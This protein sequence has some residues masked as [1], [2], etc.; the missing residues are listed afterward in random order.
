MHKYFKNQNFAFPDEQQ[1]KVADIDS[2]VF[3]F[4]FVRNPWDRLL[5][6]WKDKV[7]Q[8]WSNEY[9]KEYRHWRIKF[10][11]QYKDKDFN[12]FVKNIIPSKNRHTEVQSN[13]FDPDVNFV[14]RFENLQKGFNIICDK[15]GIP[16]QKLPHKNK[17]QHKHYTEYYDEETKEIV[18]E[19]YAKDIEYFGYKF[20]EYSFFS[21]QPKFLNEFNIPIDTSKMEV[22][23]QQKAKTWISKNDIVLELGGRY[24]TVSHI[25]NK[26]L[27][28]PNNHVVVEPDERAWRCLENNRN[29]NSCKFHIVKGFISNEKL[30][31]TNL[32]AWFGGYGSHSIKDNSSN[33]PNYTL[34]DIKNKYNLNFNTLFADC[35]G[36]L[37]TFLDENPD[38]LDSFYKIIFEADRIKDL[39]EGIYD[40][41]KKKLQSKGFT[42]RESGHFNVYIKD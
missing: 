23:D 2:Y 30:S 1:S 4:V 32:N 27:N 9:P 33:T 31:L 14:G 19:K 18:A 7:K 11:E 40:E 22:E 26:K 5:S 38:V 36:F 3:S 6:T 41:V 37:P 28:N 25:I 12:F 21:P 17:S 39:P 13:L 35:E 15:I 20:G 16:K 34:A 10:F 42:C 24:G 29:S 8:Q